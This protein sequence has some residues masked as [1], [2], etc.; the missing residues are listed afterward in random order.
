MYS[1][2]TLLRTIQVNVCREVIT[3]NRPEINELLYF[4]HFANSYLIHCL[5]CYSLCVCVCVRA[6]VRAC[7]CA[8]VCAVYVCCYT[9]ICFYCILGISCLVTLLYMFWLGCW[10]YQCVFIKHFDLMLLC[11]AN[12]HIIT[13]CLKQ[14][15]HEYQLYKARSV[16][17]LFAPNHHGFKKNYTL[18]DTLIELFLK[19]VL[20]SKACPITSAQIKTNQR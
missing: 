14:T 12:L 9:H 13:N 11:T 1:C 20:E 7:V 15:V 17:N 8:C 3:N 4:L 6:C 19:V 10:T 5:F 2:C 16:A 18:V